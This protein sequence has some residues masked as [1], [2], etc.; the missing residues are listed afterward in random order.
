VL[1]GR[2]ACI[3]AIGRT[4]HDVQAGRGR[5]LLISGEAGIGKSRLIAALPDRTSAAALLPELGIT[6]G[7]QD[8]PEQAQQRVV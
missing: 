1:V 6:S 3:A 2:D 7:V 4:L 5:T 8:D